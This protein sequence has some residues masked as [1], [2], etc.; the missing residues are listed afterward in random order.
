[1]AQNA[2]ILRT[3]AAFF[4]A[5]FARRLFVAPY[6]QGEVS[7][8]QQF[9][10]NLLANYLYVYFPICFSAL[11]END[12]FFRGGNE[13]HCPCCRPTLWIFNGYIIFMYAGCVC[14]YGYGWEI[15]HT[16]SQQFL[17]VPYLSFMHLISCTNVTTY[18]ILG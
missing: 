5:C 13:C 2:T 10:K 1:M 6:F 12:S 14:G 3:T 7:G 15:S 8:L 18:I 17:N 4:S 9:K 11:D 16:S